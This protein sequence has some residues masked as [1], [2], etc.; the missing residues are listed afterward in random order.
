MTDNGGN[1]PVLRRRLSR[2]GLLRA[3]GGL[4]TVGGLGG[5]AGY[6]LARRAT[7]PATD[8][9]GTGGG[10]TDRVRSYAT[11]P[12][13][14]IPVVETTVT[15]PVTDGLIFLTP[16]AGAGGRGPLIVDGDGEPVWFRQVAGPAQV[17]VDLRV[18]R[19]AGE[20]VLTWWEGAITNGIGGGEFVIADTAYREITRIRADG[21]LPTDQHDFILTAD[22]TALFFVYE[23]VAADLST[24]G[25]F[26]DGALYDGVVHEVEVGTGRTV[27]RWQARDHVPLTESYAEPPEGDRARTP[28][29]YFHPNSVD[30]DT[31]GN[32]L[33][34]ARHTWTVYKVDRDS[35][36][37][38]WRLGGRNSDFALDDRA[39]FSWQHDARRRSDGTIGIFDNRAGI[40]DEADQ[41]RGLILAVDETDRTASVVRELTPPQALLA[42]TQGGVQELTGNG[43]FV[44]WGARPHFSEYA[45]DGTMV[46]AGQLP[47]DN[48][49]YR[50]YRF[51]WT[52]QPTDRPTVLARASSDE[53]VT[54]QV[55]WNGATEVTSWQV[56]GGRQPDGL[57]VL[58]EADRTGFETTVTVHG[59][60]A[61]VVVDALGADRRTL[62]SSLTVPVRPAGSS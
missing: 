31:D 18:Q 11:R 9:G 36:A 40:T 53:A 16:A 3:G 60:V 48:G 28:F 58:G 56:R 24:V 23:L 10:G 61:F 13:L 2:R 42:R 27:R 37:V 50:A 17:A 43:S 39:R 62:A 30:V 29:D 38:L 44:G 52:G 1:E 19:L 7:G 14:R 57:A 32:L 35:G 22:G 34:S 21:D 41:S 55:S 45:E 25:G 59:P 54:V 46:L 51:A 20:P 26:T 49:S 4:L 15:G 33:I 12:D 6:G 5:A 47:D 8:D